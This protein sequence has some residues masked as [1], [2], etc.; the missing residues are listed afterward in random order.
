M[1]ICLES[2]AVRNRKRLLRQKINAT[3]TKSYTINGPRPTDVNPVYVY[4]LSV[5]WRPTPRAAAG[6]LNCPAV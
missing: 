4:G 1:T 3:D 6:T 2:V 5:R